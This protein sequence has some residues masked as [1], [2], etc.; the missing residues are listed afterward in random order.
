MFG[1]IEHFK[2]WQRVQEEEETEG[3]YVRFMVFDIRFNGYRDADD[4]DLRN[5]PTIRVED[6]YRGSKKSICF[7]WLKPRIN[8]DHYNEK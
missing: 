1:V 7:L 6:I 2:T 8:F 4:K 5:N 3:R